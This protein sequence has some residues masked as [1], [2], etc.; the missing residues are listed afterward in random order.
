[1]LRG[2]AAVFILSWGA[3]SLLLDLSTAPTTAVAAILAIAVSR[4]AKS[5]PLNSAFARNTASAPRTPKVFAVP[6]LPPESLEE[7]ETPPLPV[8]PPGPS[9]RYGVAAI[10]D[11]FFR[12]R[13]FLPLPSGAPRSP[14]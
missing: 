7:S 5:L 3:G 8:W 10:E 6:D 4:L 1:M 13:E 2:S 12:P 11:P 14:R 9:R